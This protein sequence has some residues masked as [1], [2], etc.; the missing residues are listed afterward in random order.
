MA[1]T[2]ANWVLFPLKWIFICISLIRQ[3]RSAKPQIGR[4]A[5]SGK[6]LTIQS[7]WNKLFLQ[8]TS[9]HRIEF[10]H[11]LSLQALCP[12]GLCLGYQEIQWETWLNYRWLLLHQTTPP[13]TPSCQQS[14]RRQVEWESGVYI[15]TYQVSHLAWSCSPRL[16]QISCWDSSGTYCVH[17]ANILL[18]WADCLGYNFGIKKWSE[19]HLYFW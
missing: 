18:C 17:I 6:S 7:K 16:N 14:N 19:L 1:Q 8:P 11:R 4:A 10:S 15:R 9:I 3:V 5:A 2:L 13:T 12:F